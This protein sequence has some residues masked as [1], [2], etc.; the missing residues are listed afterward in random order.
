MKRKK[1][2]SSKSKKVR[3]CNFFYLYRMGLKMGKS[4]LPDVLGEKST[5][6]Q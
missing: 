6:Y 2:K 5:D 4:L 1:K 3:G